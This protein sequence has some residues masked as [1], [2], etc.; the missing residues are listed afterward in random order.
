MINSS[1]LKFLKEL[2]SNNNKAWFDIHRG[3][4]EIIKTNLKDFVQVLIDGISEFDP[5]IKGIEPKNCVF[6]INRDIRFAKDKSPYK[7]NIG[8]F[9]SAGGKKSNLPGYYL[10]IEPGN[11]F[12]AGGLYS[13]ESPD[14]NKVRQEIDYNLTEFKKI[15]ADKNFKKY[16]KEID[17]FDKLT[18]TPKGYDKD[19]PAIEF[20][21][22]KSYIVSHELPDSIITSAKA[23][24]HC[25]EV[26]KAMLPFHKFL[27]RSLD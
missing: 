5:S 12:L 11:C 7:K 14:L 25:L 20:L 6:R 2:K 9:I 26:F 22:H 1:T 19:N 24:K 13:P 3:E 23:K 8:A 21:K 10:H 17:D 15:V 4:Y 16:F 18:T 27:K